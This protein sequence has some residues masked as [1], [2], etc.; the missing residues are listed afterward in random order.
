MAYNIKS[1]VLVEASG[2]CVNETR[3]H[4]YLSHNG[5]L[6]REFREFQSESDTSD[7]TEYRDS[8]DNGKTWGEWIRTAPKTKEQVGEDDIA[9]G[10]Y[11]RCNNVYNP[12]HKHYITVMYDMIYIGGYAAATDCFWNH[13][14]FREMPHTY[15]DITDENGNRISH[16]LMKYEEGD[17]FVKEKYHETNYLST[18][19]G[20]GS[21]LYIMKNGDILISFC[22]PVDV[23]CK[24]AGI[25]VE[26]VFPHTY[27]Q[28]NAFMAAR[29]VWNDEKKEYDLTFSEPLVLD[30]RISS[31]GINEPIMAE[32]DSG[33]ILLV[34]RMSNVSYPQWKSRISPYAPSYKMYSIS[35]DGGK[36]F[37]PPMPWHFDSREVIY[38]SA[39]Y[40]LFVRSTKNGR[41]YWFGNITDPVITSGNSPRYPLNMVEVDEEWGCAKKD[42]LTV[43]ETKRDNETEGIQLSNFGIIEDRES[44]NFE[45]YLTKYA[46]FPDRHIRDCEVW[47][48]TVE[49]E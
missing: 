42:S 28:T 29:G 48:Y 13:G 30:S 46:Q 33:K 49:I 18:N 15:I 43:I 31:R 22:A 24:R 10:S 16:Q 9:Q 36:T 12:I 19:V 44:G 26:K 8:N 20:I 27:L 45:L 34:F 23:C 21:D 17:G 47:K 6:R 38:S 1:E 3:N 5:L 25:D 7:Y 39:T 37:S 41:L 2:T 40:S 32:L 14:G 11:P 4:Y 35:D